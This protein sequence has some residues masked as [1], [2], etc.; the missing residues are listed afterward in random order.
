MTKNT[1][2]Q[3]TVTVD[4]AVKILADLNKQKVLEGVKA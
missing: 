3:K 1:K 4:D 2:K